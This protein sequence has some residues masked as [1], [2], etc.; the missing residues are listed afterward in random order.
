VIRLRKA[1]KA[2]RLEPVAPEKHAQ[3]LREVIAL[4]R[5]ELILRKLVRAAESVAV[6]RL[7]AGMPPNQWRREVGAMGEEERAAYARSL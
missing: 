4:E 2:D 5:E 3:L 7:G 1:T 6:D